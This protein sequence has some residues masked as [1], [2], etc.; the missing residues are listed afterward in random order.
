MSE[1]SGELPGSDGGDAFL[2][3]IFGVST[4][5]GISIL[6]AIPVSCLIMY[7][8]I[9]KVSSPM[10][11][12]YLLNVSIM[13]LLNEIYTLTYDMALKEAG[14]FD[15][16]L[17]VYYILPYLSLNVYYFQTTLVVVL[18]YAAFVSALFGKSLMG[19]R[20]LIIKLAFTFGFILAIG[21]ATLQ[22]LAF[23]GQMKESTT[24]TL[25][26][27]RGIAQLT[28][29]AIT[30]FFCVLSL[31]HSF[32]LSKKQASSEIV[33]SALKSLRSILIYCT[34][35]YFLLLIAI[36]EILCACF[37]DMKSSNIANLCNYVTFPSKASNN[38]RIFL[39]SGLVC[40][41]VAPEAVRRFAKEVA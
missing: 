34:P 35:P 18:S 33:A 2:L 30:T 7:F 27:I 24:A 39:T 15:S 3:V 31:S 23:L 36:P 19:E 17:L 29:I 4:I 12:I 20:T 6:L 16:L 25:T 40:A 37:V 41:L 10:A 14:S 1:A 13:V 28:V 38:L 22:A 9:T 11:R 5:D 32:V 26:L 8:S 21:A